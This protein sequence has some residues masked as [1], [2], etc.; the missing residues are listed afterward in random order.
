MQALYSFFQHEKADPAQFEK[1]L[2]KSLD[3]IHELYFSILALII[4]LH[5]VAMV[6]VDESKNKRLPNA[7]DLNPNLKFVNKLA[8]A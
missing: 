2:F 8:V 4:D 6:M 3:K 5:H 1:E 7:T